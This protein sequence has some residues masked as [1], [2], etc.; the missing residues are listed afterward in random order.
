M[1][2]KLK[3]I[4]G[5]QDPDEAIAR[6][7]EAMMARAADLVHRASAVFAGGSM[8]AA[9][10]EEFYASDRQVNAMEQKIRRQVVSRVTISSPVHRTRLLGFLGLVR[11]V[12]RLGDYAK[13]ILEAADLLP[14]PRPDRALSPELSE[15]SK[16]VEA[17]LDEAH[18]VLCRGDEARTWILLDRGHEASIH[19]DRLLRTLAGSELPAS[20]A[21]PCA[22]ATRYYKRIA[23]H[24][25][26]LL[27]S[28]VMPLDQV[29]YYQGSHRSDE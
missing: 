12:E 13:N 16:G 18:D 6:D 14:Q 4:I 29:G 22:L 26:N 19:C 23:K 17:I 28:V 8:S 1:F 27:S 2:T 5:A 3:Q 10:R 11:D 15:I 25:M 20:I 9:Q 24:L 21:V 7:L